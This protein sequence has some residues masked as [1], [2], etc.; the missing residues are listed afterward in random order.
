MFHFP[1]TQA[2][3][4]AWLKTQT[5]VICMYVSVGSNPGSGT[6]LL[7]ILYLFISLFL[8]LNNYF[9]NVTFMPH[10]VIIFSG[11]LFNPRLVTPFSVTGRGVTPPPK[12]MQ[13]V[14]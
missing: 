7:A 3:V 13:I 1:Y 8:L 12:K 4:A 2:V 6:I 14:T 10:F 5:G 11:T 9:G